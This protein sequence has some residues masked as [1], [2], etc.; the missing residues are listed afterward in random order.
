MSISINS[1]LYFQEKLESRLEELSKQQT[2]PKER[3]LMFLEMLDEI[4]E[5]L[6]PF[7]SVLKTIKQ[8]ILESVEQSL[9]DISN[10]LKIEDSYEKLEKTFWD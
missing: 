7:R 2:G 8:G 3:F 9:V 10:Q 1:G 6:G 5:F 4:I